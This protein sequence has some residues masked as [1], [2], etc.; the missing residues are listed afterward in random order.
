MLVWFFGGVVLLFA[1]KLTALAIG[2]KRGIPW[3][4]WWIGGVGFIAIELIAHLGLQLRGKD[5]FYNG[6]G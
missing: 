5:N 3:S 1:V 4:A 2:P 6:R